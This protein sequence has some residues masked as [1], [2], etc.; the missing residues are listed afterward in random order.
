MLVI[1]FINHAIDLF[2]QT[3]LVY[4]VKLSHLC[5]AIIKYSINQY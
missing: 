3:K 4:V 1:V 2:N 5:N